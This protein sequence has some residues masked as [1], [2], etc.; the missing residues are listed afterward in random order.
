MEPMDRPESS[1]QW[2]YPAPP[3]GT[4]YPSGWPAGSSGGWAPPPA[5]PPGQPQAQPPAGRPSGPGRSTIAAIVA[6]VLALMLLVGGVSA[7]VGWVVA[8]AVGSQGVSHGRVHTV[9]PI[10]SSSGQATQNLDVQA[11]ASRVEPAVVDINTTIPGVGRSGQGA[12][13]GMLVNSSGAVLT[14]NHV[15][16][17]ATEI[18]V[19]IP[20]RSSPYKASVVGVDPSADVALIQ[21]SGLSGLPTVALADSSNLSVGD[22]VVAIGNALGQGGTP[23]VTQ[24]SVTGLNRSITASTGGGAGEQLTGLIESD[25]PISPG[26]SGGPLVNQS[27]QV[28]GMITAGT[29]QG[30]R[31]TTSTDGYAVPSSTAAD[32]INQIMAGHSSSTITLGQPGYLGVQAQD[33]DQATAARLGVSSGALVT[34]VVS[35]SPASRAG[36]AQGSVITAI[37]DSSISSVN[38]LRPAIR[39]HKPG[40]RMQVTWVDSSGTHTATVTVAVGPAG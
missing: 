33:V 9:S 23:T 24:G 31:Q 5:E 29:T 11:I 21:V 12:A 17:G 32:I 36:I 22:A 6:G 14:N 15:V 34:G 35:G 27:G 39:K 25:A 7:G 8:H 2:Q 19:T 18:Q 38:D 28:I 4:P 20:G 10:H 26:D 1:G 3:P 13:T 16:E 37:D 40:D 30:R